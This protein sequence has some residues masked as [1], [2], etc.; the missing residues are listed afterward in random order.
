M[1]NSEINSDVLSCGS[2]YEDSFIH[3]IF[4][5]A[6]QKLDSPS[7]KVITRSSLPVTKNSISTTNKCKAPVQKG[8][9]AKIV[10]KNPIKKSNINDNNGSIPD[11]EVLGSQLGIDTLVSNIASLTSIVS[12]IN[13]PTS[14]VNNNNK[15]LPISSV[16]TSR[17]SATVGP[18]TDEV[19]YET[20]E[21]SIVGVPMDDN[22]Y[23]FVQIPDYS[24]S[25]QFDL[26]DFNLN[27]LDNTTNVNTQKAFQ[28]AF[29]NPSETGSSS[30]VS[31]MAHVTVNEP[32]DQV[33]N[34]PQL[35][36]EEK[37]APK[38]TSG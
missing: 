26:D 35:N 4:N 36:T 6:T 24:P 18:P 9:N 28:F 20:E 37:T 23:P 14:T 2:D 13:R 30:S 16:R 8:T 33:W 31:N 38:I 12:N 34:I 5:V 1:A 7:D 3:E 17:P 27:Y 21:T 19:V 29:E 25:S 10:K 32:E 22:Y 11:L 15:Q